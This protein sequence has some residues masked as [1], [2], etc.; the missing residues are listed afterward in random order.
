MEGG[1][2]VMIDNGDELPSAATEEARSVAEERIAMDLA[3]EISL[4][5]ARSLKA[6]SPRNHGLMPFR[7]PAGCNTVMLRQ[8]IKMAPIADERV[9]KVASTAWP[10]LPK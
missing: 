2:G 1:D 3:K 9:R 5:E 10:G 6:V 7:R 4:K 8:K